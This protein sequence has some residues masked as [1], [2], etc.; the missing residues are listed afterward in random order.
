MNSIKQYEIPV[1][2]ALWKSLLGDKS[3]RVIATLCKLR[4]S[5]LLHRAQVEPHLESKHTLQNCPSVDSSLLRQLER[6]KIKYTS[7]TYNSVVKLVRSINIELGVKIGNCEA[8]KNME[9]NELVKSMLQMPNG[10]TDTGVAKQLNNKFNCPARN[11]GIAWINLNGQ[12]SD[13]MWNDDAALLNALRG[14]AQYHKGQHGNTNEINSFLEAESKAL[15]FVDCDNVDPFRLCAALNSITEDLRKRIAN[16]ILISDNK[17]SPAW[18]SIDK[19]VS[20]PIERIIAQRVISQKSQT[21]GT[22]IAEAVKRRY[23]DNTKAIILCSSDSDMWS[24]VRTL[25]DTKFLLLLERDKCSPNYRKEITAS[26]ARFCMMDAIS[27]PRAS[28]FFASSLI[29]GIDGITVPIPD[30]L[31]ATIR[32][33]HISVSE[34]DYG[35]LLAVI[36]ANTVIEIFPDNTMRLR[37]R[38]EAAQPAL[39]K[40]CP[41]GRP[42]QSK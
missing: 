39:A 14:T 25:P 22:L 23:T 28:Y 2:E 32:A 30:M 7:W 29:S 34:A 40:L 5:V 12:Y 11:M 8:L 16:I 24:L 38:Q 21:D 4:S 37:I 10:K 31:K 19:Y 9:Y 13:R 35:K 18:A 41:G 6:D 15:V 20:F 27:S 33:L 36:A 17:A 42:V 1:E 26:N 3:A